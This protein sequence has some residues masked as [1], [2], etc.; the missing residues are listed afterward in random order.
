MVRHNLARAD[1]LEKIVAGVP[2]RERDPWIRQVSD[3]L[4]SAAQASAASDTAASTRLAS[5]EKQLVQYVPGSNL[6]AYVVFRRLQADYSR[7]LSSGNSKDFE[8]VQKE[9]VA[10]L[11][12]FVKDYPRAE[13]TPDAM[14][15]LG[16]VSEF[17][18][19]DVEARNWYATLAKNFP[20][21]AQAPKAV[22]AARRLGLEGQP[23]RLAAPLLDNPTAPFDVDQLKGK[24]VVVY[25]WASWNGQ[26]VGDFAKLR[27][28]LSSHGGQVALVGVNLDS[29]V[30]DAKSFLAKNPVP[31][32]HVYQPGGLECKLAT[33]Y[34]V[35][36]LPSV[37]VVGKDGKCLSRAAQVSTLDDEVKKLLKK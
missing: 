7:K 5:L 18:G 32:T 15:Q 33:D 37:F 25:Y 4:A 24:L 22:G 8:K 30:E 11:T 19:K 29:T 9:W 3:S 13:D 20:N 31:G 10:T 1:I 23:F 12:V 2:A 26:A 35:M 16:M 17:L 28:I 34:G 21:T 14:L 36:M 27:S 6:T